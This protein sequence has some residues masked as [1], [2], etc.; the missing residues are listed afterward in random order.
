MP[1]DERLAKDIRPTWLQPGRLAL[2]RVSDGDVFEIDQDTWETLATVHRGDSPTA[3]AAQTLTAARE[4]GI[5]VDPER[6]HVLFPPL[7]PE[8]A[9]Y[10]R[11]LN[12]QITHRCHLRCAH[13]YHGEAL[14]QATTLDAALLLDTL[15]EFVELGGLAIAITGGE[16]TLHPEF[17]SINALLP[18]LGLRRELFTN[19]LGVAPD[20]VPELGFHRIRVSIDGLEGG[21]E[22][23][24]GAGTFRRTLEFA[25]AVAESGHELEV[26]T[27]LHAANRLELADLEH[28]VQDELQ[29]T[30]W[31]VGRPFLRGNW[32][33]SA[34]RL[35]LAPD[36][37]QA[38]AERFPGF[39]SPGF[40]S[41]DR[42]ACDSEMLTI[43]ADGSVGSCAMLPGTFSWSLADERLSAIWATRGAAIESLDVGTLA[44]RARCLE[45][46]SA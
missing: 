33:E 19:G 32:S 9:P 6:G 41:D 30:A 5:L 4:Y 10:L 46:P 35:A 42:P 11:Y 24:R 17:W 2:F 8:Q 36:E 18:G 22:A 40:V 23:V 31:R 44:C 43:D 16:P 15:V 1:V 29:A 26:A 25:H 38:L 27:M 13:C 12:L 3:E 21:H 45:E 7:P 37:A 28:L 14:A 34:A 20:R 39:G